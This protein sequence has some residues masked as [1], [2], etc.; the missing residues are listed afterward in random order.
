M[1]VYMFQVGTGVTNALINARKAIDE[2]FAAEAD[3]DIP[4]LSTS[5]A[6]GVYMSVSSN[7]RYLFLLLFDFFVC[8]VL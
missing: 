1:F 4:I 5:V 8:L 6:Y 7:L 3:E 2:S